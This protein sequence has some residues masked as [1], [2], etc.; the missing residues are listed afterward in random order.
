VPFD[1]VASVILNT[2]HRIT[3]RLSCIAYPIALLTAF[4]PSYHRRP[5]GSASEI[6]STPRLSR[7][8]L[9]S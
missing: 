1:H 5:K 9:I 6:R 3:D 8:G 2:N 4:G 7:R